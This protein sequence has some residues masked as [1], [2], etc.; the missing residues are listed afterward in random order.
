MA[1]KS[2]DMNGLLKI[3]KKCKLKIIEDCVMHLALIMVA[4][5]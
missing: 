5:I 2:C 4:N 1:G 3:A